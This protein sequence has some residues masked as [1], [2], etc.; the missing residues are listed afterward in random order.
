MNHLPAGSIDMAA[1]GLSQV[2]ADRLICLADGAI[3]E[4]VVGGSTM[5]LRISIIKKY[6]A[7]ISGGR[8]LKLLPINVGAFPG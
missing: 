3:D 8:K 5:I 1:G 7:F 4:T 2:P 6:F